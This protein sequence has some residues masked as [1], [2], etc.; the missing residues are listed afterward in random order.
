MK[1]ER[2]FIVCI[3]RS[4]QNSLPAGSPLVDWERFESLARKIQLNAPNHFLCGNKSHAVREAFSYVQAQMIG[5]V[6]FVSI[7]QPLKAIFPA[8]A[9]RAAWKCAI[10]VNKLVVRVS[11]PMGRFPTSGHHYAR[12]I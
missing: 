12:A 10:R 9:S 8:A 5:P 4:P 3:P 2:L 11:L 6:A 1:V 7:S